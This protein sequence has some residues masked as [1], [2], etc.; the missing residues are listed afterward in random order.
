MLAISP[1]RLCP[2]PRTAVS[3]SLGVALACL[4]LISA[5][6]MPSTA[7]STDDAVKG[8]P[9]EHCS[10]PLRLVLDKVIA[11]CES[12]RKQLQSAFEPPFGLFPALTFSHC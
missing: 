7:R 8:W 6:A 10:E 3:A 9:E 4:L 1:L 2:S 11:T 5:S 12:H